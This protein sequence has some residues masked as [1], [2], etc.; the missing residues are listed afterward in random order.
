MSSGSK[1]T[2]Q[3]PQGMT[4]AYRDAGYTEALWPNMV[5]Y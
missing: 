4:Q 1:V 5:E 2:L 3:V